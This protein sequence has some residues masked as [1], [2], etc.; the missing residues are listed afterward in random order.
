MRSCMMEMNSHKL[1]TEK[2][3]QIMT[4][5][6]IYI[7]LKPTFVSFIFQALWKEHL[8]EWKHSVT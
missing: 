6:C 5:D 7:Y 2:N 4:M 1:G 3:R 8:M